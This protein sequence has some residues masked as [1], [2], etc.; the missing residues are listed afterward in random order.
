MYMG[1][2]CICLFVLLETGFGFHYAYYHPIK[3]S[4]NDILKLFN[5]FGGPN[6]IK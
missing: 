2:Q 1:I 5:W 6:D 4:I 3:L